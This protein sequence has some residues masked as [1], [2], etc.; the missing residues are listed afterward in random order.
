MKKYSKKTLIITRSIMFALG[1]ALGFLAM[2]GM[3]SAYPDLSPKGFAYVY[4]AGTGLLVG[5]V[6]LLS[7][8]SALWLVFT[9]CG[10][11]KSL[12]AG[13]RA[14]SKELSRPQICEENSECEDEKIRDGN[15][16]YLLTASA[17]MCGGIDKFC[18][19]WLIGG[20][21]VLDIT[22][23]KLIELGESGEH[24][25]KA[26]KTLLDCGCAY[27][28]AV[29]KGEESEQAILYAQKHG[30]R[31]IAASASELGDCASPVLGFEEISG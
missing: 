29:G 2:Y 31:I 27:T 14:D 16:G 10:G 24:A 20:A 5:L 9:V 17:L 4:C 6:L 13:K 7:S 26:Y 22:V 8:S 30:L 23:S 15:G 3:L 28:A 18:R 21:A 12:F 25:L 11:V 1:A 19:D